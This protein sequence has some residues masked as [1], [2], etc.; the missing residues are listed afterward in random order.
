M[1]NTH[2]LC[3][4]YAFEFFSSAPLF[5]ASLVQFFVYFV[6]WIQRRRRPPSSTMNDPPKPYPTILRT[7]AD[8]ATTPL[9]NSPPLVPPCP[10]PAIHPTYTNRRGEGIILTKPTTLPTPWRILPTTT[11]SNNKLTPNPNNLNNPNNKA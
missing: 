7:Q 11:N 10:T 9:S 8:H 2:Y 5:C 3:M 1:K 4:L 6:F